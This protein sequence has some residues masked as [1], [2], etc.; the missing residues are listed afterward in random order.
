MHII[1]KTP[2][3]SFI[4]FEGIDAPELKNEQRAA[5]LSAK[6]YVENLFSGHDVF[7][8]KI[9][10]RC[11]FGRLMGIPYVNGLNVCND[12]VRGGY[13]KRR[14][15]RTKPSWTSAELATIAARS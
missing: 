8:V 4:R 1:G 2:V 7:R 5:G 15:P 12:L 3:V 9:S 14:S 11:R 10:G 6:K 13:A